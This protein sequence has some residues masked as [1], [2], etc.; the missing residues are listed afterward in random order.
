MECK[1]IKPTTWSRK[2][3]CVT[4]G[5]ALCLGISTAFCYSFLWIL[6]KTSSSKKDNKNY[7]ETTKY[8][9][10]PILNNSLMCSIC[11][12]SLGICYSIVG[13]SWIGISAFDFQHL[14]K[15]DPKK[16]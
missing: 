13:S 3:G 5:V 7:E 1:F 6:D 8:Y 4:G 15:N 9:R 14:F 16:W 2:I 12:S 11:L 10:P